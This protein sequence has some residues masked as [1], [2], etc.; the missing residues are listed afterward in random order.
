MIAA[1]KWYLDSTFSAFSRCHC[2]GL[3]HGTAQ[4][5]YLASYPLMKATYSEEAVSRSAETQR[6]RLVLVARDP[7]DG[8]ELASALGRRFEVRSTASVEE[9]VRM[10]RTFHPAAVLIEAGLLNADLIPRLKEARTGVAVVVVSAVN[11][12]TV[13]F[14]AS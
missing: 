12:A 1:E 11:D 10:L 4:V 13:A 7:A 8:R 9:C 14:K 3:Q 5:W 6:A 2:L